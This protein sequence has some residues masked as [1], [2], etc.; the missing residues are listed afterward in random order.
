[1]HPRESAY[2]SMQTQFLGIFTIN[3]NDQMLNRVNNKIKI[4]N[5]D[6]KKHTAPRNGKLHQNREVQ[7]RTSSNKVS[8]HQ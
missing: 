4:T 1:M 5:E 3:K 7:T 2:L 6:I 8:K